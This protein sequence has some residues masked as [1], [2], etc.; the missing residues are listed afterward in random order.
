MFLLGL[1]ALIQMTVLP[2]WLW[3]RCARVHIRNRWEEGLYCFG[4]SLILNHWLVYLLTAAGQNNRPVW[5]TIVAAEAIVLLMFARRGCSPQ[6]ISVAPAE[7]PS[8]AASWTSVG[9]SAF[10][11]VSLLAFV[12]ILQENWGTV[13]VSNDDV[14]SWDRWA[15]DW[16]LNRFPAGTQLYPQL[17]PANWSITYA[18]MGTSEVKMFAKAIMPAFPLGILFLFISLA[19]TQRARVFL[20][21]CSIASYL[22]LQY[23]GREFLMTGYADVA[24]AFF[25]FLA[26]Y[27]LYKQDISKV[28]EQVRFLS[29]FFAAGAALTKQGGLLVLAAVA[30]YLVLKKRKSGAVARLAPV[31]RWSAVLSL[32][33]VVLWYIPKF[34]SAVY[35]DSNLKLVLHDIHAGRGYLERIWYGCRLLIDAG[36]RQGLFVFGLVVALTLSGLLFSETRKLAI[37]IVLP[38]FLLWGAFFSYEIRTAAP[39]FPFIALICCL[40]LGHIGTYAQGR[41]VHLRM[42]PG[43]PAAYWVTGIILLATG[44]LL[45]FSGNIVPRIRTNYTWPMILVG[46]GTVIAA[47]VGVTAR[48]RIQVSMPALVVACAGLIGLALGP[49]YPDGRL[50]AEQLSAQRLMGNAAVN[51]RLYRLRDEGQLNQPVLS[52]YWYLASLPGLRTLSRPWTCRDCSAAALLNIPL[53][54]DAGFLLV[55]DADATLPSSTIR[56]VEHCPGLETI[57]IEGSIRLLRID[58]TRFRETCSVDPETTRPAI[59]KLYPSE[60]SAGNGFNV[61]PNGLA[62]IGTV[63]R[64]ASRTTVIVWQGTELNSVY[65]GPSLLTALVPGRLY[66][67]PGR[68]AIELWDKETGLRSAPI[69]FQV[70]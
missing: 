14:A 39:L 54:R 16:F 38:G 51:A 41:L 25:S 13:F 68:Y 35:G 24:L 60:T 7:S 33:F 19:R 48:L 64:N 4:A 10:A 56:S 30:V 59:E 31:L 22:F 18:L 20:G 37:G 44:I 61:Q 53:T 42:P 1:V 12:P 3:L 45:N 63:C 28:P 57:F 40:V 21:G 62:A 69:D 27:T 8:E 65:A 70:K 46:V 26:F 15:E 67:N 55:D 43:I 6:L 34:Y 11:L 47:T 58:R 36:G 29:L 66:K 50:V 32:G 2:G 17:L 49:G 23:L 5:L 52:N 9:V